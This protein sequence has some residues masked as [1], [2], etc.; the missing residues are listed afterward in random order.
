[1]TAFPHATS[2]SATIPGRLALGPA[3]PTTAVSVGAFE[4]LP[5]PA[6]APGW[7]VRHRTSG[8]VFSAPAGRAFLAAALGEYGAEGRAG[9]LRP[10]ERVLARYRHQWWEGAALEGEALV[11]RGLLT[12][13]PAALAE[14]AS[15]RPPAD[16]VPFELRLTDLG[17][18]RLGIAARVMPAHGEAF[19][20]LF[21]QQAPG[22][23]VFGGGAQFTHLDLRGRAL[24]LLTA[25]Q[26]V[27]RGA[28]PLTSY[29]EAFG[30]AGG[31]WWSTYAPV[32]GF[33][34][35]D[36]AGFMLLG[37]APARFDFRRPGVGCV[38][39]YG[40]RLEAAAYA[41][42]TPAAL[43]ELH[44]RVGGRMPPLP[45]WAHAGAI[46]GL[47][48]GDEKVERV[49][50][51]LRAAGAPLAGVWLQDWVGSRE[52]PFGTRLWW[53]WQ[54]DP[55]RYPDW[56]GM[57]ERLASQGV[58]LLTYVNPFIAP[59]DERPGGRPALFEA[60]EAA[61]YFVRRAGGGTYLTDQGDFVAGL[62]DLSNPAARAWYLETLAANLAES[63]ANG[64][65][66][67]FGEGLPLDARLHGG[68]AIEWHNRYPEAWADFNRDLRARV[69]ELAGGAAADYV[70]FFR[71]GYTRS[72][73][74]AGLFWLGDQTVTWDRFD[75]MRSALTGLL[76]SG[77][78][79][80][81]LNHGDVGGYTSTLPPLPRIVRS[82][83]L[84]ARWAELM[85]FTAVLRTHEGNRPQHN[86]QVY[87]DEETRAAFARAARLHLG[88]RELR[89]RLMDEAYAC[90][91]PVAR[92]PWLQYPDDPAC[93]DLTRQFF[94][95]PDLLVAPVLEPGA[96][97][98]LAYLPAGSGVWRHRWT[99]A[100]FEAG[101]GAWVEV[102][103]PL[104][105]PGLFDRLG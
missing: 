10:R 50:Q 44:T 52:V 105:Q 29:T 77:F 48:G 72:P 30:G 4:L 73:G 90:G 79:G 87:T 32:P 24:P 14:A 67:D 18:E 59:M 19:V 6:G 34:T 40:A 20:D 28:Q 62:I 41:A 68:E 100:R 37:T 33:V 57:R 86:T 93:A 36:L 95:G 15:G 9:H 102:P 85:A 2:K 49:V 82:P 45:D 11:L 96:R 60:A 54:R 98:V 46:V 53:D 89:V 58:R 42:A 64:W 56:H 83:E 5:G 103:A 97:T 21:W 104:G 16:A 65:M 31:E 74:S 71:S 80:F 66:A 91:M 3:V 1:M 27:G 47:Q 99:H 23:R 17:G 25:E 63:G 101:D 26:G 69:A 92:H 7:L 38:R 94:L 55:V 84:L 35:T 22:A 88:W 76:S 78:S 39:Y 81:A 61:G 13:T 51:G 75:G 8:P 12:R 43:L 70:T